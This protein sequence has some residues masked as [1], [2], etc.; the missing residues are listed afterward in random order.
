MLLI[1]M[2]GVDNDVATMIRTGTVAYELTRPVDLYSLWFARAFSGR[3]AP[4]LMRAAPIFLIAGL[5]FGLRAPASFAAGALFALSSLLGLLLAASMITLIT[6]SLLWTVSGEGISRFAP[7]MI[8]FFSGMIIPLPLFPDWTQ[9]VLYALPFRGLIDTPFRLYL[10]HLAGTPA[11]VA[12]AQQ[13]LWIAVLITLG[14]LTLSR[15]LHRLV[16]Q[17]G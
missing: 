16:V 10:G 2:F 7:P 15:G 8:M 6:L 17:G 12:I 1:A 14:R 3:A 11:L 4:L 13:L 5:F 9:P